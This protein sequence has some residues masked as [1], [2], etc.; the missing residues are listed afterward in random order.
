MLHV[1]L[2]GLLIYEF[3]AILEGLHINDMVWHYKINE[4]GELIINMKIQED[5]HIYK[6]QVLLFYL[7]LFCKPPYKL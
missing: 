1:G 2:L 5:K 4:A 6:L 3:A 7:Q